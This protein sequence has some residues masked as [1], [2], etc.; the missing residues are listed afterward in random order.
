MA[1]YGAVTPPR[2]SLSFPLRSNAMHNVGP[3]AIVTPLVSRGLE[4][5]PGKEV[6]MIGVE[7]PPGSVD[8]A[9][10]HHAHAF[11][12]VLD[13]SIVMQVRGGTSTTLVAGQTF[14]EGPNDVHIVGRN[15]SQSAP[16]RFVV[17]LVKDTGAPIL[18]PVE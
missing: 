4:D 2:L 8:A 10:T 5:L 13:G 3:S 11:V 16:A 18:T 14:Y 1:P 12:Y 9:H 15:A 6:S 17:F 7:Y